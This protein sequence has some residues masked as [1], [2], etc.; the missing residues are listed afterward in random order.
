MYGE[1]WFAYTVVRRRRAAPP[2]SPPRLPH[3]P[4]AR[5]PAHP[6]ASSSLALPR[7]PQACAFVVLVS[8]LGAHLTLVELAA[9]AFPVGAICAAWAV[10]LVAC[11]TSAV[12]PH[13]LFGSSA[14]LAYAAYEHFG[15]FRR[16]LPALV[17]AAFAAP[18]D[19]ALAAAC[20]GA[21]AALLVPLYS[22][23]FIPEHDGKVW[24]G[25]SCWADLPIH[26][27]MAQSFLEGR[28]KDVSWGGMASPVFA[29]EPMAYPFLPDFHAATLVRWG[30]TLRN[31]MMI[32]G[33]TLALA[34]IALFF[35]LTVR[36]TGSRLGGL[37]AVLI[38][39]GAGG[40]GGPHL[41]MRDGLAKAVLADTAQNDTSGDG[42]I[43]WFAFIPHVLLPQRGANFAYPMVLFVLTLVWIAGDMRR[44]P[45]PERAADAGAG[46]G[47]DAAA[48]AP[49]AGDGPAATSALAASGSGSS[50]TAPTL[51]SCGG[52]SGDDRRSMLLMSALFAGML[53]LIQAHSFVAL[54][55]MIGCS[56]VLDF[57]KWVADPRLLV[58]WAMA[59][60]VALGAGYPQ[61]FLFKHQVQVGA[62]GHFLNVQWWYQNHEIGK[63]AGVLGFW[64]FWWMNLGPALPLFA[65]ALA[66]M[67]WELVQAQ[68]LALERKA[69]LSP[70]Q[71]A[72]FYAA[73]VQRDEPA[74]LAG[75][76][77]GAASAAAA[78]LMQSNKFLFSSLFNLS[79]KNPIK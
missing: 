12:G 42:K 6:P 14:L 20:V 7:S 41:A 55:V 69:A 26:M 10:Y 11:L 19:S 48:G 37:L 76:G 3:H 72:D 23:R 13:T 46:A 29:G 24:S 15:G 58:S 61:M 30:A 47:A 36:L 9:G 71:W 21:A 60:A 57:H 34:L 39:V 74:P 62:G 49:V 18:L 51:S 67:L 56:F 43:V 73:A 66:L 35:T 1:L 53:P 17:R 68:L 2:R 50:A 70:A 32:P 27:H 40:M 22:S 65:A 54:G 52:V 25:G 16:R 75:A 4:P 59:G 78:P 28:N 38:A 77:A 44:A 45:A 31:A 79:R 8:R 63:P 64:H 5:P 33:L